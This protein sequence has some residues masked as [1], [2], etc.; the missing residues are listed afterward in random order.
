MVYG[1]I[2]D[3]LRE[4]TNTRVCPMKMGIHHQKMYKKTQCSNKIFISVRDEIYID[5]TRYLTKRRYGIGLL[6]FTK[7]YILKYSL[8]SKAY[9]SIECAHREYT[10]IN[11]L[12]IN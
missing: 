6:H 8:K 3:F 10:D 12:K 1:K 4:Y 2:N 7:S 11:Y 5:W 9:H